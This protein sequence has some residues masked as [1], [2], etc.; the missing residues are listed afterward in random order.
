MTKANRYTHGTPLQNS[1][2]SCSNSSSSWC[3]A[4][5]VCSGPHH[6]APPR[7]PPLTHSH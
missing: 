7:P 5:W 1:M 3:D 2:N 6:A 4:M